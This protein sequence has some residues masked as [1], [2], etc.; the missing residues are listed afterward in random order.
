MSNLIFVGGLALL[1]GGVI[2]AITSILHPNNFDPRATTSRYWKPALGGQAISYLLLV[3]GVVG[4]HLA[5]ADTTGLL[6]LIGFVLAIFGA[7][8]TF[9]TNLNMTYLLPPLNTQ[10]TTPKTVTE[11]VGPSG[12][13]KWLS[14]L[15][16]L[17]LI[18]FLPGFILMGV[19]VVNAGLLPALAGWLLIIGMVVSNV[20]AVFKPIFILR[21]IGGVVFGIGLAWLG[22]ALMVA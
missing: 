12:P 4:L 15:T 11:L 10:Q 1:L 6:G 14:V 2:W 18:T 8:L 7:A 16:C 21:N 5:Q 20:G 3:P 19:A 13:L 22:L 17:Y 9:A